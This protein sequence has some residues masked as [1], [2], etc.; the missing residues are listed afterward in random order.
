MDAKGQEL[1]GLS[2]VSTVPSKT[3]NFHTSDHISGNSLDVGVF[4]EAFV[5]T[6]CLLPPDV[7]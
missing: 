1:L 5:H 6:C 7:T 3:V 4:L 2:H